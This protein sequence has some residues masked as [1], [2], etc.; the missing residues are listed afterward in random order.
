VT[1]AEREMIVLATSALND[2]VY[3]V[4]HHATMLRLRTRNTTIA[5]QVATKLPSR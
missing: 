3:C 4:A 1:K 5:D 2:S